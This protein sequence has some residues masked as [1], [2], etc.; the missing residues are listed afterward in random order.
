[1]VPD[2]AVRIRA[3]L[4]S[5]RET[6]I[7]AINPADPLAL[8]QAYALTRHLE[9]LAMQH[10]KLYHFELAELRHYFGMTCELK[11]KAA[12]GQA[13]AGAISD[14][15]QILERTQPLAAHI[16]P[17]QQEIV[18]LVRSLKIAANALVAAAYADGTPEFRREAE[19][20]VHLWSAKQIERERVWAQATGF[21]L[22]AAEMPSL[23]S[24]LK[25]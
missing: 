9:V 21:D 14:A 1:M 6:I 8:E 20:L 3:M 4:R 25:S 24:I 7:P 13:I 19:R 10:D 2:T 18:D 12:G 23:E 22:F 16:P 17:A 5:L 15:L 11:T